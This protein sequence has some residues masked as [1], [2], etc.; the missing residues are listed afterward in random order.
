MKYNIPLLRASFDLIAPRADRFAASFYQ[1]LFRKHPEIE[2]L[3]TRN[4]P[5]DQQRKLIQSLI[6]IMKS[7][8]QPEKLTPFLEEMG[9]RHA[10]Y[11]V[12]EQHYGYVSQVML[13]TLAEFLGDQWTDVLAQQWFN[14]LEDVI[15]IMQKATHAAHEAIAA[16]P[17][18]ATLDAFDEE[19]LR[20]QDH[21]EELY[22][23]LFSEETP[24]VTAYTGAMVES[25]SRV[26]AERTDTWSPFAREEQPAVPPSKLDYDG[27]P[28]PRNQFA[29]PH[30]Q[31]ESVEMA[32]QTIP[33]Q[34]SSSLEN[35]KAAVYFN[36]I[37]A[38]PINVMMA[39]RDLKITYLNKASEERL[40]SLEKYLP[41][42]VAKMVGQSIDI[43]HKNPNHQRTLLKDP[44]NLPHRA[45]IHVGPETLD[46]LVN[47][48]HDAQG[49]YTGAMVTWDVITE[50]LKLEN[51]MTRVMNMMDNIPINVM[52]ANLDFELVYMNP[53]S[54]NT[55][56][57]VEHLLPMPVNKMVGQK[58]D[59]FHKAPEQQRKLLSDPRNL[60]YQAKIQLADQVLHL[61]VSAIFDRSGSYVGPM[62]TWENITDRIRLADEIERD[63]RNVVEVV[64]SSSN[65]MQASAQSMT[66]VSDQTSRQAQLVAAASEEATKN[67]QTV[68]S[69]AEELSASIA[70]IARHV[71]DASRMT[72]KAVQEADRTNVTIK[73]LG[74]S[75]EQIGQVIK[76][77]TSIAQQTNLLALNAT[78]EAARA[79]E[80]G[81]GFAVVANE[82]KELARQTAKA[83]EE[84]SEKIGA[85]QSATGG[86]ASAI[87]SIS[88]SISRINEISTTIAS[89]VE[90]QTAATDEIARNVAEAATGTAEVSMNISKVSSAAAESGTAA[91]DIYT[92]AVGLARE[93]I[94][95]NE[96][97]NKFLTR[98]RSI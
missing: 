59:V 1:S 56:K 63:I 51:E 7:L 94:T 92:A 21:Q 88:E 42:P 65:E 75:S 20:Y 32:T 16:T 87:A 79:G 9:A 86:A 33:S 76:V 73:E 45:Q 64:T 80:A 29:Q 55:L 84:I 18:P 81:K 69:S 8:D 54:I 78:I 97:A 46:L 70:E 49:E 12:Q 35:N 31:E 74:D 89:A 23:D 13:E 48:V 39:D 22:E 17:L 40:K 50:K 43:F 19:A 11:H 26:E 77:I 96:T 67:V 98:M 90:E 2:G 85:I 57:Q 34:T 82:V 47:A 41:I 62:V 3:F 60:P 95:L 37:E 58:I 71:Q 53:A 24:V 4:S 66:Q 30:A 83:T 72:A 91:S 93:S 68:A 5:E 61:K 36:M 38:M 14:A 6:V 25:S 27:E 28:I 52:M 15:C 10:E 44:R